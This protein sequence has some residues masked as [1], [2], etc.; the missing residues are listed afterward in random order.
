M[1][2]VEVEIVFDEQ[3]PELDMLDEK[4]VIVEVEVEVEH[5]VIEVAVVLVDVVELEKLFTSIQ[6]T[7]VVA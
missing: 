6:Q 7:V 1:V 5:L 2:E 3:Q 4:G